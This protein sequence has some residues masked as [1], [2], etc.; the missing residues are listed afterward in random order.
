MGSGRQVAWVLIISKTRVKIMLTLS[1]VLLNHHVVSLMDQRLLG[2]ALLQSQAAAVSQARG[3]QLLAPS[4]TPNQTY[5]SKRSVSPMPRAS[6]PTTRSGVYFNNCEVFEEAMMHPAQVVSISRGASVVPIL[7]TGKP[8]PQPPQLVVKPPGEKASGAALMPSGSM[9]VSEK[10]H[11]IPNSK[12]GGASFATGE[13]RGT[14]RL[15]TEGKKLSSEEI[16]FIEAALALSEPR[17]SSTKPSKQ[18]IHK[19][20]PLAT[21]KSSLNALPPPPFFLGPNQD[22]MKNSPTTPSA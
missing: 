4:L 19:V 13:E 18:A 5:V 12:R 9:R 7:P 22:G 11:P 21:A 6:T 1:E 8:M 10:Q 14:K 17:L 15:R 20:T 3:D 16:S 2:K